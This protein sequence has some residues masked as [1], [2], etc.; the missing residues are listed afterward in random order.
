MRKVQ[1]LRLLPPMCPFLSQ[2]KSLSLSE[3][4]FP[5]LPAC[6]KDVI[7]YST[8]ANIV[9]GKISLRNNLFDGSSAKSNF[10]RRWHAPPHIPSSELHR[11]TQDGLLINKLEET[12]SVFLSSVFSYSLTLPFK[13]PN[14]YCMIHFVVVLFNPF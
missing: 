2:S 14:E 3:K 6:Q 7:N 4:D 11:R 13:K 5:F 8:P 1:Y 12:H 10:L 9:F